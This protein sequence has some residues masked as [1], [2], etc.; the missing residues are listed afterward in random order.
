MVPSPT[1][2]L[3]MERSLC[4]GQKPGRHFNIQL[5]SSQQGHMEMFWWIWLPAEFRYQILT[6]IGILLRATSDSLRLFLFQ[7][8]LQWPHE[9]QLTSCRFYL[10]YLTPALE[11]PIAYRGEGC[12]KS[13][14]CTHWNANRSE[15]LMYNRENIWPM[16]DGRWQIS[17]SSF[18]SQMDYMVMQF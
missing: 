14:P 18:S 8:P 13:L 5:T 12:L 7:T 6:W 17:L 4:L 3:G 16:R 11:F 15:E 1:I 10:T 9:L 2:S